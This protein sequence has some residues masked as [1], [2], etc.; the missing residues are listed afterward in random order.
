MSKLFV[1]GLVVISIGFCGCE[2]SFIYYVYAKNSNALI[3]TS[4]SIES[5]HCSPVP[6]KFCE[7]AK[8]HR[9]NQRN[10]STIYK[11]N[12]GEQ[13]KIHGG[14]GTKASPSYFPFQYIKIITNADTLIFT[15]KAT[16]LGKFVRKG[17][18]NQ[19]VLEL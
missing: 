13:L 19:W 11:I 15:D 12:Q 8:S 18:T 6:D 17:K 14:L 16:F 9:I 3:E 2:T 7:F 1:I 5:I 4:P 10:D